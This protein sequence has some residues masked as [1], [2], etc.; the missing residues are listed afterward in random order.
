MVLKSICCFWR[1]EGEAHAD[2][3]AAELAN[4]P[5]HMDDLVAKFG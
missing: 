5:V 3:D 1:K 4:K 2:F